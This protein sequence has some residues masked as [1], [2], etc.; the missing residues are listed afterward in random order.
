MSPWFKQVNSLLSVISIMEAVILIKNILI[1]YLASLGAQAKICD[2]V[3]YDTQVG[4]TQMVIDLPS[5]ENKVKTNFV[6]T[7]LFFGTQKCSWAKIGLKVCL[8]QES[9]SYLSFWSQK[10]L[11]Q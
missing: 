10:N 8:D 11:Y 2:T 3:T 7:S 1:L 5:K 4:H 9:C 6:E